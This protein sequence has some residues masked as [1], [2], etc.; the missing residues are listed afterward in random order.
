MQH[1]C[2]QYLVPLQ[3]RLSDDLIVPRVTA[4]TGE[5]FNNEAKIT[6]LG[7]PWPVGS[8]VRH[9]GQLCLC[10]G[11]WLWRRLQRWSVQVSTQSFSLIFCAPTHMG[12]D[13]A[14][15]RPAWTGP[16]CTLLNLMPAATGKAF[17]RNSSASWGGSVVYAD[18]VYHMYT[19]DSK[20]HC[21]PTS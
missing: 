19:A 20:C 4:Q 11:L 9:E 8:C 3:L 1:G 6:D 14:R 12:T 5:V 2:E 7:K 17:Y 10:F 15:C 16:N 18:G 21:N 13:M